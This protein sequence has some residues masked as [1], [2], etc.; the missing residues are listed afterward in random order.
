M[1]T[2]R[3]AIRENTPLIIGIAGPTKSGK[4]YSALRVATGLARGG[5]IAMINSEG[6]RGHQYADKF[7]YIA[8]ELR[9][10]YR[11]TAYTE[12]LVAAAEL[13]PAV[14]II[15]STS[16]M[17]DGPGG[18]L[19]WHEELMTKM[20]LRDPSRRDK[21]KGSAWIEPKAAENLCV[22]QM[23]DMACPIILCFRAKEKI[24]IM[25]DGKWIDLGWQPIAGE[26]VAFETMFTLMLT[27]HCKG[28]PDI[29]LSDMREPFDTLIPKGKPLDESI[30]RVLA[31]WSA[32]GTKR[33]GATL[34]GASED[35]TIG[36]PVSGS[37]YAPEQRETASAPSHL[38]A[39][40]LE[41]I[42]LSET[43]S[44]CSTAINAGLEDKALSIFETQQ[45]QDAGKARILELRKK[46]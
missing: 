30:G 45:I 17:H 25:P 4:T 42:Q 22:Y 23:I 8:C 14:V 27:P 10:P 38:L 13:K 7:K 16:H 12:A 41:R 44:E 29:S 37:E 34:Q 1:I 3:P 9:P 5:V 40:Y 32:G 2:F 15:D 39:D 24:K 19:E 26:R 28:V 43:V 35:V 6:M 18:M 36:K 21:M 33:E 46:K 11:P 31:E 20:S